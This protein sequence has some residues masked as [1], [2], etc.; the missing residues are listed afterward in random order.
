[1]TPALIYAL[2]AIGPILVQLALV[3]GAPWGHLTMGGRWPGTL[4]PRIRPLAGLQ[5]LLLIAMTTIVLNQ[6]GVTDFGW[7]AWAI[8]PVLAITLL[9]TVANFATP[10]RMER[11][12]WGPMTVL[13]SLSLIWMLFL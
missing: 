4:P 9:S 11:L 3:L 7:P 1:M 12:L 10:S 13:M 6:A 5:A 8:W 2:A